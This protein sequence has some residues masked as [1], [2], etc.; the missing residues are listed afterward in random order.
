LNIG[1]AELQH[2]S[3]LGPSTTIG[4]VRYQGGQFETSSVETDPHF[5]K[6]LKPQ[7]P[8]P[9]GDQRLVSNFSRFSA[10][11]YEYA[12]L[13]PQFL[14]A[15]AGLTYDQVHYPVNHRFSPISDDQDTR[16]QVSPKAG[17]IFTPGKATSLRLV[18]WAG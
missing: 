14:T 18:P 9:L 16:D 5:D 17:L 2:I 4:G 12:E 6:G 8:P 11:A 10:Y 1:T 13:W 3:T 15:V 7:F